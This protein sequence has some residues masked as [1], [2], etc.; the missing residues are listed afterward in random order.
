MDVY[1]PVNARLHRLQG[2]GVKFTVR[3]S[4]LHSAQRR[5]V[6]TNVNLATFAD[7]ILDKLQDFSRAGIASRIRSKFHLA[8]VVRA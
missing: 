6:S 4:A 8:C 5:M 3:D 1:S 7:K 2:R